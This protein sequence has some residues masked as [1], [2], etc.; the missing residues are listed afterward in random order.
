MKTIGITGG[1][2]SGKSTVCKAFETLGIP[3][4]N[5]D[6][7]AKNIYSTKPNILP[8]LREIFGED[9][10]SDNTL[11][12]TKL[13]QVVF[14]DKEKLSLLNSIIHPLVKERFLEWKSKQTSSYIIRETAILIESNSYKDC[15]EIILVSAN[16]QTRI[17]RVMQRNGISEKEVRARIANQWTDE[18]RRPYCSFEIKNEDNVLIL[19]EIYR[20]HSEIMKSISR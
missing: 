5:A 17:H 15:D 7:E 3:V 16:E 4:F 6:N 19:R 9:V 10:F 13:A 11:D 12:K 8:L 20:I 1:I 2:G 18:Q 14:A